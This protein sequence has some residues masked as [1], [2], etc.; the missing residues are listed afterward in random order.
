MECGRPGSFLEGQSG[1]AGL[2]T[3]ET[4]KS[5]LVEKPMID[6]EKNATGPDVHEVKTML[7][8]SVTVHTLAANNWPIRFSDSLRTFQLQS[9]IWFL[10]LLLEATHSRLGNKMRP[11]LYLRLP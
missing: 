5:L 2:S 7:G 3:Y 10:V 4:V 11:A 6:I 1:T 8:S 9:T